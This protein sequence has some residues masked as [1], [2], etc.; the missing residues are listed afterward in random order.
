MAKPDKLTPVEWE[1]MEA[2]W[3]LGGSPSVRDVVDE[4][5]PDGQ[6]AYTTVQTLMNTLERKGLL[7]RRKVGLVNFY[8]PT[9]T[10]E[11]MARVE[12][13]RLISK[14][15]RGSA[16][17]LASTLLA[18]DDLDRTE[19]AEIRRLLEEREQRLTGDEAEDG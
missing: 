19:L 11:E 8:H 18:R 3:S 4:A 2:V 9:R 12:M 5:Y 13:D 1:I 14:V 16:R 15:F 17:A 6:K 7:R 10:R